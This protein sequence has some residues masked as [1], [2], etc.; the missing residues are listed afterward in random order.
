MD[1]KDEKKIREDQMDINMRLDDNKTYKIEEYKKELARHIKIK[2]RQNREAQL[3][4]YY[5]KYKNYQI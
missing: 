2:N 5:A 4:F 3:Q 1:P